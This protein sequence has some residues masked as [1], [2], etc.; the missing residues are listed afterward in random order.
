MKVGAFQIIAP[1]LIAQT[2]NEAEA[3]GSAVWLWM[4]SA[5]HR[6]FPLHALPVLL[7]P[8]IKNRQFVLAIESGRPVFYLS[9]ATFSEQAERRYLANS[10]LRMP[11][12]DWKS[13]DRLWFLDW[14]APFGHSRAMGQIMKRQIFANRWGRALYHRGDERGLQ[15][16]EFRGLA[17]LPEEARQWL[18]SHP[19]AWPQRSPAQEAKTADAL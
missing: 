13:G 5:T 2:W 11:E 6:D 10:P 12:A 15:I 16:K 18:D 14:L 3:L 19:V 4:N 8:A 9:W 7:L 17:T 1:G